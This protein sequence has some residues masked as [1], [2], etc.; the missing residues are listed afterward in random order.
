MSK[1]KRE[2]F[3]IQE[4][5]NLSHTKELQEDEHQIFM[6]NLEGQRE[7]DGMFKVQ[8]KKTANQEYYTWQNCPSKVKE[9]ERLSRQKLR[10]FLNTRS[11]LQEML[12]GILL[13][14]IKLCKAATG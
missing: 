8:K 1:T 6:R 7:W 12:K 10:E 5:S 3:K 4:K 2:F 11:P 9:R 13:D 14:E